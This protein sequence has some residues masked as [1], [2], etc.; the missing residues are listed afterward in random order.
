MTDVI[1]L[2][3]PGPLGIL[4]GGQLGRM[5]ALVA[6][7]MGY[8]VAVFAPGR[9]TPA[10]QVADRSWDHPYADLDALRRFAA[11]VGVVTYE[12]ENVPLAAALAAAEIVP[13]RPGPQALAVA[14]N[15]QREKLFLQAQ[16]L[17]VARFASI[18]V[19]ADLE[20]ALQE[21]GRPAVLKTAVSG[22]DGKGQ[23]RIDAGDDPT[24]AW[25]VIDRQPAVLEAFLPL[26]REISVIAARDLQ[27]TVA[28]YEPIQ[29]EHRHH[30][31]DCSLCPAPIDERLA[32]EAMAFSKRV[33]EALD[34]VGVFCVE[35]FVTTAGQLLINEIAPR[36]HNSGHLTIE[37]HVTSQFE[38]QLRA[39]CGL[40]LGPID[41]HRPAAM[42]NLL[43]DLWRAGEPDWAAACRFPAVKLHLYGKQEARPGRKMGHLTAL[44]NTIEE[45]REIA[46]QARQA[47]APQECAES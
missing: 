12:F 23:V 3:P 32:A 39:V 7:R 36:P 35:F 47:L 9:D 13:V 6:R 37:S 31:L 4:G 38:Q 33:L 45:A 5:L 16:G 17:P 2:P 46:M 10:G 18:T 41:R 40:P 15:R 34:V 14:Q 25:E 29:N 26:E 28:A 19:P 1:P 20:R 11:S 8:R 27:G 42:V 43:G 21:V 22:Y 44:A 24:A 30:I